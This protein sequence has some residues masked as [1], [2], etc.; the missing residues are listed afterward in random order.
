MIKEGFM[1][2]LKMTKKNILK[3]DPELNRIATEWNDKFEVT[4][5]IRK[6]IAAAEDKLSVAH[7]DFLKVNKEWEA[8]EKKNGT[9]K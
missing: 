4:R 7:E 6:E 3:E 1:R 2:V 5:T 8:Y 9:T